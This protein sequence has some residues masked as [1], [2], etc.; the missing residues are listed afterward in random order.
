MLPI[1]VTG[2]MAVPQQSL[3]G[4]LD[5]GHARLRGRRGGFSDGCETG[6]RQ[7]G[8]TGKGHLHKLYPKVALRWMAVTP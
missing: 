7:T 2:Y 3:F 8:C 5:C 4:S 1:S 6:H